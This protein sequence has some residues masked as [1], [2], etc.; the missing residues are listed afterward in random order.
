M[1]RPITGLEKCQDRRKDRVGDIKKSPLLRTLAFKNGVTKITEKS[2]DKLNAM[3]EMPYSKLIPRD[4]E[5]YIDI[6]LKY[7]IVRIIHMSYVTY[8]TKEILKIR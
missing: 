4:Q 5:V 7:S 6:M 3:N 8:V 2:K 1:C